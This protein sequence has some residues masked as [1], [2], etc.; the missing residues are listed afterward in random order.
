MTW[1]SGSSAVALQR[2]VVLASSSRYRRDLLT[3]I[4]LEFEV[5]APDV[6]EAPVQARSDLTPAEIALLLAERKAAAVAALRPEAIVIG[7]DQVATLDGAILTKP[8]T[9]EKTVQQLRR[10]AGRTHWLLTAVCI[11]APQATHTFL[12]QTELRMRS[13]SDEELLRYADFDQ[14]WDCAGGYRVEGQGIALFD[15]ITTSDF[16]AIQGLPLIELTGLL[17]QLGCAIP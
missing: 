4:G 7:S 2:P 3:Q 17:R 5:L 10:L 15:A 16:T 8:G 1:A 14:P 11:H 9:R 13:F 12:N 6:D